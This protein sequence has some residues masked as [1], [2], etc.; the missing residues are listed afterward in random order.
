MAL[1][2][3]LPKKEQLILRF[4]LRSAPSLFHHF[5]WEFS[6]IFMPDFQMPNMKIQ[7]NWI[8]VKS[9][10]EWLSQ[11]IYPQGKS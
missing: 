7:V 2:T 6:I 3:P 8:V 5:L 10:A 4:S 11:Q 9:V 1:F